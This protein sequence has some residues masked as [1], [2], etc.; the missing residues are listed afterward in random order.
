MSFL[1]YEFISFWF[2]FLKIPLVF[3]DD[4]ILYQSIIM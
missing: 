4:N 2:L 1:Q 3:L